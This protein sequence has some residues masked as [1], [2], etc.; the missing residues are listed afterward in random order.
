MNRTNK[1]IVLSVLVILVCILSMPEVKAK[2]SKGDDKAMEYCLV[3]SQT[4]KT[5]M[6]A[7]QKGIPL[8]KVL[9]VITAERMQP[10]ILDIYDYPKFSTIKMQHRAIDEMENK[11]LVSCLKKLR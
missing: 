10:V 4:V 2:E 11:A 3:H 1:A 5:I 8:A 6:G 7:R 9:S